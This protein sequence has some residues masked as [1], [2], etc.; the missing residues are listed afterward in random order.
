MFKLQNNLTSLL[1]DGYKLYSGV[2]EA[3]IRNIEAVKEI[4]HMTRTSLGPNGMNKFI[5]NHLDKLYLTKDSGVMCRELDVNH[6]A[7][8]LVV[9]ASKIQ[10]AE[11]GDNTNYVITF[12][13]ELL[14]F[15]EDLI[16][17]G[18]HPSEI[19][20]GYEKALIKTFE[21]FESGK[22]MEVENIRDAKEVAKVIRPV[23]STK[24]I[25]RQDTF[26]AGLIAECKSRQNAWRRN[27]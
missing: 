19:V 11:C 9:N 24:M 14:S 18:V 10:E 16:K 8:R 3:I 6:P 15:A 26:L 17:S 2:E 13:G 25:L 27:I 20:S 23:I 7:V 12:A 4:S 1:K 5:V 22:K 21:L